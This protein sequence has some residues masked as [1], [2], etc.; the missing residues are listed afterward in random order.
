MNILLTN[1]DG[2]NA[3]GINDLFTVLSKKHNV[4]IFAP[5]VERSACSNAITIRDELI[6][7]KIDENKYSVSGFPADCVNIGINSEIIPKPDLVIS[8]I[9]HG[10]NAGD[11]LHFSGTVAGARTAFIYGINS[12]AAS[13]DCFHKPSKFFI[14][15]SEFL[16]DFI[17]EAIQKNSEPFYYNIN[18]P[19]IPK[20]QVKGVKYTFVGSRLYKD[21][22]KIRKVNGDFIYQLNGEIGAIEIEGS[23]I[24]ELANNYIS[25]TPLQL[26][27]T[28][29]DKL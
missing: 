23:D 17:T 22:F 26:D 6:I 1:D 10:P 5:H 13:L 12:I 27:T 20:E 16:A 8:G 2:I 3:Q 19:N 4:Y 14:D 9:N 18:Y 28:D 29:K 11:D 7:K 21:K 25:I 24:T 15:N